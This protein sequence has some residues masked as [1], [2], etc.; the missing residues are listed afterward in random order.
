MSDARMTTDHAT[1]RSWAEQRGGIPSTVSGTG[2]AKDPGILR[3]DFEPKDDALD[4]I[5]W[6]AFFKKFDKEKLAFLYQDTTE[7]G[8]ESRFHKFVQRSH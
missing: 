6:D 2:T 5:A 8:A 3:F 4:P 1:I 7:S